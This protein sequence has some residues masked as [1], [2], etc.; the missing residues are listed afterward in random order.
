MRTA[1]AASPK[2]SPAAA[3]V[4][5][6]PSSCASSSLQRWPSY[7]LLDVQRSIK[8]L[9]A[10]SNKPMC[11][12][13]RR[14]SL[15][16]SLGR[17]ILAR[18]GALG[19]RGRCRILLDSP[20]HRRRRQRGRCLRLIQIGLKTTPME[21]Q[22]KKNLRSMGGGGEK[23]NVSLTLGRFSGGPEEVE[24][25]GRGALGCLGFPFLAVCAHRRFRFSIHAE[26]AAAGS[27][28]HLWR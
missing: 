24:G 23:K 28:K 7:P 11:V 8:T 14:K 6:A 22:I 1:K 26:E 18:A 20:R 19:G 4:V 2:A 10:L 17:H 16:T 9:T 12:P 13:K 5:A 3:A 15:L 21:N 25:D 27:V